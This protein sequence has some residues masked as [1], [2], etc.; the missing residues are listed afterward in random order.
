MANREAEET[1]SDLRSKVLTLKWAL[2]QLKEE[3]QVNDIPAAM[4]LSTPE[5]AITQSGMWEPD[6][7]SPPSSR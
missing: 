3:G 1:I 6:T 4:A 5:R 7:L 2:D